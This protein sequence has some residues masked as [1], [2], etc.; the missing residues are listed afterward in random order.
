MYTLCWVVYF[1]NFQ[2]ISGI[3]H[4][5]QVLPTV[6]EDARNWSSMAKH[7]ILCLCRREN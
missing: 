5:V 4:V 2:E 7:L 3:N 1:V 6:S